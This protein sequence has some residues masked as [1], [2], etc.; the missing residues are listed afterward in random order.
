VAGSG[1]QTNSDGLRLGIHE[2]GPG[3]GATASLPYCTVADLDATLERVREL[4][5][6]IIHPGVRRAVCRDFRGHPVRAGRRA[7]S[8]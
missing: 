6:G 2:R 7:R 3:P 1:W 8:R 5:G 4:G